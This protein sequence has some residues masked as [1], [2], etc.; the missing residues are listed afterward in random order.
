MSNGDTPAPQTPDPQAPGTP[1]AGTPGAA[2]AV[3]PADSQQSWAARLYLGRSG[4]RIDDWRRRLFLVAAVMV[5]V[6]LGSMAVRGFDFGIEFVGGNQFQ[7]PTSAGTLVEVEQAVARGG[8]TVVSGQEVGGGDPQYMIRTLELDAAETEAVRAQLADEFGLDPGQISDDRVSA[9]WGSEITRQALVAL[10]VFMALVI[11]Y[12]IIRF[13]ALVAV[14]AVSGLALDLIATAGIY[15]LVGFEV[16]PATVIGF[17]TIMGFGLYDSV[18]VFDKVHE[19]T[20]DITASSTETY[21][22]AANLAINQ[23]MIRSINTS[24]VALLP[25]GGL[26]FIGAGLL[27][28][29]TLKD[30]GLVLFVG[31]AVS[32]Y[33]SLFLA[34]PLM[35]ELKLRQPR[36]WTHTQ[37]VLAK[38]AAQANREAQKQARQQDRPAPDEPAATTVDPSLVELAGAAPK[39]GARPS[40]SKRG[41]RRPGGGKRG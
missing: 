5:L 37:R 24:V 38:R 32:F 9:A 26:L 12:L 27:G 16:T 18:V 19:N 28:A 11:V 15:S 35:I 34:A 6:A 29:G 33:T 8:A 17:L 7:V 41:R 31:M 3:E 25:V 30:L 20:K 4:I 10:A 21:G 39:V 36:F 1:G 13:E 40:Q 14:A 22:E 2:T 23:V